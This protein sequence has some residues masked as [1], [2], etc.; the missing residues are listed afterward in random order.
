MDDARLR[1]HAVDHLF[2]DVVGRGTLYDYRLAFTHQVGD[3]A[4]ADIVPDPG[5]WIEGK[6][7]RL[8][9]QAVDYLDVREGRGT[10]YNRVWLEV[11]VNGR[12]LSPVLSYTVID[13]C[14]PELPPPDRYIVEILRGATGTVSSRYMERLRRQLKQR[15][16]IDV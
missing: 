3:Y 2:R 14:D 13:K 7:Y 8:S 11:E 1:E 6:V 15:F 4:Y 5:K 10:A 12:K 9:P 16:Q